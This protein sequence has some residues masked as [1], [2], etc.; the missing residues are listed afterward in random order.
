MT[1]FFIDTS[2]IIGELVTISG[3]NF[4]HLKVLRPRIG[5]V[6]ELCN[7]DAKVVYN[8]EVVEITRRDAQVKIV[9]QVP[10]DSES[11]VKITL[12]QGV[13][14]GDKME[15]I[16]QKCVELGV[17]R[18]VPVVTMRTV[19]QPSSEKKRHRWQKIAQSEN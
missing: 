15:M 16:I 8:A 12:F 13:P 7:S 1:R 6:L 11:A 3:E 9:G 17:F 19:S 4:D 2:H 10:A 14:K 18:I 5:E